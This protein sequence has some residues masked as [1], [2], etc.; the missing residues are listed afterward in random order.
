[1]LILAA[2]SPLAHAQNDSDPAPTFVTGKLITTSASGQS[3][4]VR[5]PPGPAPNLGDRVIF[6]RQGQLLAEGPVG[7]R[8][9]S[10]IAVQINA[11]AQPLNSTDQALWLPADLAARYRHALPAAIT[12]RGRLQS[13]GPGRANGWVNIGHNQ[14]LAIDHLLIVLHDQIEIAVARVA[15]LDADRAF[16]TLQPIVADL[17]PQPGAEVRLWPAPAVA[18]AG[19]LTSHVLHAD[20]ASNEPLI[21]I[22]GGAETGLELGDQIEIRRANDYI[23]LGRII[24]ADEQLAQVRMTDAFTRLPPMQ[25]DRAVQR[26]NRTDLAAD[27]PGQSGRIF[28][29]EGDYCLINLGEQNGIERG[30]RLAVVHRGAKV[31]E[32]IVK[33]VK[34]D[35]CGANFN[36]QPPEIISAWDE[37]FLEPFRTSPHIQMGTT[38]RVTG[39]GQCRQVALTEFAPNLTPGRILLLGPAAVADEDS[40]EAAAL[41]LHVA[42][43]RAILWTPDAWTRK[44]IV[45]QTVWMK[46]EIPHPQ[47]GQDSP[48]KN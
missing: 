14:G 46:T 12:L 18:K 26:G 21:T 8:T 47:D 41:V 25:G 7:I 30:D 15:A 20:S 29:I 2:H 48:N 36:R 10:D 6:L 43:K 35:Y 5:F 17:T 24:R 32:L 33:T 4:W 27:L 3:A 40:F 23:G 19:L 28:R 44:P 11:R 31:A 1:M 38:E 42:G 37:V 16:V 39:S 34:V 22:A 45:S 9:E 13:I